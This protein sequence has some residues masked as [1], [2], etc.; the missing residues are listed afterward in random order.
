MTGGDTRRDWLAAGQALARVLLTARAAG[1]SAT[2]LNQPLEVADLRPRITTL[3]HDAADPGVP[4]R[5]GGMPA[6]AMPQIVLR[7]GCAPGTPTTSRAPSS[8]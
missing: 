3:V 7:L 1:V 5:R 2:Y 6:A 4:G 8:A